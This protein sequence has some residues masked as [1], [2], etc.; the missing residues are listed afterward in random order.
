[1]PQQKKGDLA[2]GSGTAEKHSSRH[3][4]YLAGMY[5]LKVI[6]RCGV[7]GLLCQRKQLVLQNVA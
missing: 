4:R 1:M 6:G 3:N 2:P 7:S 5:R